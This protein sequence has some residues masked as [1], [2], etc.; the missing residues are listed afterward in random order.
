MRQ[1]AAVRVWSG[2][3]IKHIHHGTETACFPI[4]WSRQADCLIAA[5]S[6]AAPVLMC[7]LHPE[8]TVANPAHWL[9]GAIP[10]HCCLD[11]SAPWPC[12]VNSWSGTISNGCSI[13]TCSMCFA[14]PSEATPQVSTP[15]EDFKV[16]LPDNV[17]A[18][19]RET[20]TPSNIKW[21][22]WNSMSAEGTESRLSLS[23]AAFSEWSWPWARCQTWC[24]AEIASSS[25]CSVGLCRDSVMTGCHRQRLSVRRDSFRMKHVYPQLFLHEFSAGQSCEV[26]MFP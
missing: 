12:T 9:H 5:I 6:S 8:V 4:K 22:Q 14:S 10:W 2:S 21:N 24:H 7:H 26:L 15:H 23:W 19:R 1:Q 20:V 16:C 13:Q 17:S 11:G 25:H 3:G 18:T